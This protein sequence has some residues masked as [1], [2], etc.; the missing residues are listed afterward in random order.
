MSI[1]SAPM[2]CTSA[3]LASRPTTRCPQ[4]S[5]TQVT[6]W[7]HPD[8][9]RPETAGGPGEGDAPSSSPQVLRNVPSGL[10]RCTRAFPLSTTAMMPSSPTATP[11]GSLNWPSSVPGPGRSARVKG[12]VRGVTRPA[13][14]SVSP[15]ATVESGGR[16][17]PHGRGGSARR[18]AS[19]W[20]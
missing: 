8:P 2:V 20:E 6:P 19:G 13:S 3:P 10:K 5:A 15:T 17:T 4:V 18:R 1:V 14:S 16:G 7:G 11:I 9:G 12:P